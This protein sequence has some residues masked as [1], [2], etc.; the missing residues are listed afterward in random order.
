MQIHSFINPIKQIESKWK[1]MSSIERRIKYYIVVH[2]VAFCNFK[3]PN[4]YELA[5]YS[6]NEIRLSWL[7]IGILWNIVAVCSQE[8]FMHKF[9]LSSWKLDIPSMTTFW[10]V[11]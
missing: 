1:L 7:Y 9:T 4:A 2:C 5:V 3:F 6:Y 11:S 10:H 8:N